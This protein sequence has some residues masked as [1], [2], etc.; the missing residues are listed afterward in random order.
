MIIVSICVGSSCH[1]NNSDKIVELFRNSITEHSLDD[2]VAL[3]GSFC[4]GKCNRSGVT[5]TVNDEVFTGITPE[6]FPSFFE[7]KVLRPAMKERM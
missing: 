4:A 3:M 5:V 7:E 6:N 2:D 1:L